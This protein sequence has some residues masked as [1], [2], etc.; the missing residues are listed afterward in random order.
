MNDFENN[1]LYRLCLQRKKDKFSYT[2]TFS[3][4]RIIIAMRNNH[5]LVD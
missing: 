5:K 4:V 3:C 1:V 2:I